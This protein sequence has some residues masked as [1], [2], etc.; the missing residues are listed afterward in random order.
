MQKYNHRL[1]SIIIIFRYI[2]LRIKVRMIFFEVLELLDRSFT[3]FLPNSS[4]TSKKYHFNSNSCKNFI[5]EL[6]FVTE[7][8]ILVV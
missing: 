8:L 2:S 1:L 6:L 7:G 4:K 5:L 3:L